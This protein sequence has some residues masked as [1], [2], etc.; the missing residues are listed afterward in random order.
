METRPAAPGRR[1]PLRG[2]ANECGP[3]DGFAADVRRSESRSLV[4]RGEAAIGKTALLQ[5]LA[6]AVFRCLGR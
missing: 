1:A 6:L 4:F 3:W 2:R 5:F